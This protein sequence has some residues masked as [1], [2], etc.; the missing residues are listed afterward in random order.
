MYFIDKK[1]EFQLHVTDVY[2]DTN[3]QMGEFTSFDDLLAF[4]EKALFPSHA[5]IVRPYPRDSK[6]F[7]F[8]GIES[9][10]DLEA[11][12]KES[13][14]ASGT[15]KIWAETDMRA[16]VNPTRMQMIGKL[17]ETLANRLSC[18][19]PKCKTPGWGKVDIEV[20][21]PCGWCGTPTED[22]KAVI[23]GCTRCRYKETLPAPH[24]K[25]KA[26]PGHCPSCNP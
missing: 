3:Y 20:G 12:F 9:K 17:S 19:C 7:A 6:G 13:M 15:D 22:I 10:A 2:M 4:A 26:E 21:L 18:A 23:Y 5:L 16:H 8:K 11:A 14:K 24:G 1:R 25:D